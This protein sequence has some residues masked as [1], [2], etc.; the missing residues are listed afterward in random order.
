MFVSSQPARNYFIL[1][2][3]D[4]HSFNELKIKGCQW[5]KKKKKNFRTDFLK[6]TN[7]WDCVDHSSEVPVTFF[8][9]TWQE[10][11]ECGTLMFLVLFASFKNLF[12]LYYSIIILVIVVLVGMLSFAFLKSAWENTQTSF[13]TWFWRTWSPGRKGNIP[14]RYQQGKVNFS[15]FPLQQRQTVCGP[16]GS[17][18]VACFSNG[19]PVICEQIRKCHEML[20]SNVP[21]CTGE[22]SDIC[23]ICPSQMTWFYISFWEQIHLPKYF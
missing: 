12:H 21:Y 15:A 5:V 4:K 16:S 8:W 6:E 22:E 23:S 1:W 19:D 9:I 14:L 3:T 10:L 18:W 17:S 20:V 13:V 11:V 2:F 7:K